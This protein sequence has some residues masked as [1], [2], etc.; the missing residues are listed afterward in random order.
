[1]RRSSPP[2]HFLAAV[3]TDTTAS[4]MPSRP[5]FR[6][7][8][9]R[10]RRGFSD[11]PYAG[12]RGQFVTGDSHIQSVREANLGFQQEDDGS[13]SN[14]TGFRSPPSHPR[15]PPPYNYNGQFRPPPRYGQNQQFR[16]PSPFVQNQAFRPPPFRGPPSHSRPPP[17][18][19]NNSQ[20]RQPPPYSQNQK[21]DRR[22][23]PLDYRVW[24][25]SATP[26]PSDC[27]RFI[28]LSYNILADYLALDHWRKLYFHIPFHMLDWQW[29]KRNIVFEIGLWS[30]D[31]MCLQEV[32]R[33]HD[34]EEELKLKGYCGIWKM[35]TGNPVDGC[36]IF[37]R[38]SRFKLL[39][40]ESI[41]FNKLG[42]RDNVAQI[43]VLQLIKPNGALP[44]RLEGANKVVVCNIHV[45]YNPNRGEIKLG[46]V[47]V[48]LDRANAVSKMW[49]DAPVVL[50]GDFN[51]TPKSPLYN[52][53]SER[54]LDLSGLDRDKVSGQASAEI[55]ARRPNGTNTREKSTDGS[56]ESIQ[57]ISIVDGK[58]GGPKT[59]NSSS[60]LQNQD[61]QD[62]VDNQQSNNELDVSDKSCTNFEC[63]EDDA[64]RKEI[65][66]NAIDGTEMLSESA[67]CVPVDSSRENSN[68]SYT[69]CGFPVDYIDNKADKSTLPKSSALEE[70]NTCSTGMGSLESPEDG[71]SIQETSTGNSDLIVR[72]ENESMN[73]DNP[74][75][76][77]QE[78]GQASSVNIVP[79]SIDAFS[80]EM[81]LTEPSC[82]TLSDPFE[83]CHSGSGESSV[84]L[85]ADDRILSIST[86]CQGNVPSPSTSGDIVMDDKLDSLSLAELDKALTDG[87]KNG[88]EDNTFLSALH[89]TD[90]AFPYDLEKSEQCEELE[91]GPHNSMLHFPGLDFEPTGMERSAYNPS[92]WTPIEIET[93]TG[94]ADCKVLAHPLILCST[95]T[96]VQ[97]NSGTRDPNGE[98][99]VTSYNRRFLGTVDYIWR[100]E[101]LQTI[102]V[103]APIAKHVMQWTPGFPTKKWGSDHVALA[104]ELALMKDAS[105]IKKEVC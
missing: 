73:Y 24:E 69:G 51:C 28:V 91:S 1:M 19:S 75:L 23:R 98:P 25:Y 27:E 72:T 63:I 30:A 36:A 20:F 14:Q 13:F 54:K 96:E 87:G 9:N 47:R 62:N 45:L 10:W 35:R 22:S 4:T 16:Q 67:Y 65:R 80:S 42:L 92:L 66:Q 77:P 93:A 70:S 39:Y 105:D 44:S 74:T 48:L 52:F 95:Y 21:L 7:G 60:D 49:N 55:C 32:D 102:R 89:N 41:E 59:G 18:Y 53:I 99:L 50:C 37:W 29:R 100:S 97:N 90:G 104:S 8:Q 81:S 12:G 84:E 5:P 85:I 101:G 46:Q 94:N 6:G 3:A 79:K 64:V 38:T 83:G 2:I 33:F 61:N 71:R 31:I 78:G 82:H 56:I 86:S 58:E 76:S 11:R 88:E 103:L 40:E 26:P 34:L 43:C 15:P 17:P 68:D 57:T